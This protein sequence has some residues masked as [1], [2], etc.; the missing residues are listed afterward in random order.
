[1]RRIMASRYTAR[2]WEPLEDGRIR[3]L[4]CPRLCILGDGQQG[5]CFVRSCEAGKM[6]LNTWGRSSGFCIDPIEKKPLNHFL[7]GTPALSFGTAGC[8][9]LC[10]FCQN[11][12]MSK[13]RESHIRATT[14]TPDEIATA[15]AHYGCRSIAYTYNDPVIFLEYAVDT[16][17]ACRE[18]GIRS[19]AVTAGYIRDKAREEFFSHMDAANVDLKSFD[20]EFYRRMV[21]AELQPVLETLEYL[22]LETDIWL[23]IT[24]LLIPGENDSETEIENLSS[25]IVEKLGSDIPL[26]F[27]AFHP[28]FRLKGHSATHPSTLIR[29]R[30]IALNC[31]IRHVYT[32]NIHDVEGASTWCHS[33]GTLL[34]ERNR[35]QLGAWHL[36]EVGCCKSCDTRCPG[37]FEEHAGNWGPRQLPIRINGRM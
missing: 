20:S 35:Y 16:A 4:L 33:C 3:C 22:A 7:P 31:G 10:K 1:M 27:S 36:D 18:Q 6:R 9:M 11:W 28:A 8:N 32:G 24:T 29:A 2:H 15:A 30:N 19:V 25:W 14:A 23:E 34:I 13:A 17:Q 21:G 26:H 12:E 37:V 5:V